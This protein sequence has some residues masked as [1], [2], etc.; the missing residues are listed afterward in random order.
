MRLKPMNP[1]V[2]DAP[3]NPRSLKAVFLFT[4]TAAAA[5][6]ASIRKRKNRQRSI[7]ATYVSI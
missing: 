2:I 1:K 3:K 5:I 7:V 6:S 4:D